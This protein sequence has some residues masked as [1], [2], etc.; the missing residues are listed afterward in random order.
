MKCKQKSVCVYFPVVGRLHCLVL[1]YEQTSALFQE[2]SLLGGVVSVLLLYS[3][4]TRN[5]TLLLMST[6]WIFL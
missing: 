3:L 2:S 5:E 6:S 1:V 4:M